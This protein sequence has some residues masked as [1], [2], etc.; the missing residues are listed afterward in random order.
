MSYIAATLRI[1]ADEESPR[2][3]VLYS[4]TERVDDKYLDLALRSC[5]GGTLTFEAYTEEGQGFR[6]FDRLD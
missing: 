3:Y 4:G 5:V 2:G 1:V 6:K